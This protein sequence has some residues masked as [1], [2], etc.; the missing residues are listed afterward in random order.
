MKLLKNP[1]LWFGVIL[2]A[3]LVYAA[4]FIWRTTAKVE[5]T[6]Y[7]V[8]FDDAMISMRYARNL[9][10]GCGL[11]W[12]AG[13]ERVEGYTNPLWTLYMA[14]LHLFPLPEAKVS[15]LVQVSGAILLAA[16]LF[17]VHRLADFIADSRAVGLM[18]AALAAFYYPLNVWSLEGMETSLQALVVSI[19]LWMAI[20]GLR[21]ERFSPWLYGLLGVSTLIRLDM[22]ALCMLMI[23]FMALAD[24]PNRQR[25]LGW[26]LGMLLFFVGGQTVLRYL[27]YGDWLPNTYY[28]KMSGYPMVLR[29]LRGAFVFFLFAW[30]LNWA[31]FLLPFAGMLLEWK[32]IREEKG[33]VVTEVYQAKVLL[34]LAF[35]IQALYSIYVGGDAWEH[36]GGANRYISI[37]MPAFFVLFA[38]VLWQI[39]QAT[40]RA[41]SELPRRRR[42]AG[43]GLALL[44]L[45]SF[46]NFNALLG[47]DSWKR[48]AL[49]DP[50]L[51]SA[52]AVQYVRQALIIERITTPEARIAMIPAG[53]IPYFTD[54][55][56]IDLFGK[57][58][59]HIAHEQ[60]RIGRD[61][62]SIYAYRPGHIKWDYEYV[63]T[64]LKPDVILDLYGDIT[65]IKPILAEEYLYVEIGEDPFY[66][67][68]DSARILWSEV[69]V[70]R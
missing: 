68:R 28:L 25:H 22:V 56:S 5:G 16:N 70:G 48:L 32:R 24:R 49:V 17:V 44:F 59:R 38:D 26:G 2:S 54:R 27:Y 35:G 20:R 50:P 41:L 65:S 4:L 37:A 39:Y 23:V 60:A 29:I 42:I 9:A 18:A 11:V 47:P 40:V 58:E 15:L 69:P 12:N 43:W 3:Y 34:A 64:E 19:A 7:F 6:R 10:R 31:L 61:L 57:S 46:L 13:G 8:L 45:L 52:S 67:R 53:A 30:R 63:L 14:A 1:N 62:L 21:L 51:F 33:G 36:Q 55:D 66:L